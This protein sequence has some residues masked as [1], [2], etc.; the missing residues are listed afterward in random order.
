M[1]RKGLIL[2]AVVVTAANAVALIGVGRNRFRKLQTIELTERELPV[3]YQ[4]EDNSGIEMRLTLASE[5]RI[6]GPGFEWLDAGKLREI[7]FDTNRTVDDNYSQIPPRQAYLALEFDG[8][9]WQRYLEEARKTS[10]DTGWRENATSHLVAV[11]AARSPEVLL[12]RYANTGR[13]LIVRGTLATRW[14]RTEEGAVI[15][16]RIVDLMPREIH[17]SLPLANALQRFAG[18]WEVDQVPRFTV[19]LGYGVRYEP[20][21]ESV[22]VKP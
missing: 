18:H 9:A 20:W 4:T 12:A 13:H 7:G 21:V 22:G 17:V 3:G 6:A 19:R 14:A 2:A 16:G 10:H 1:R 5:G 11:D 8:P 15:E